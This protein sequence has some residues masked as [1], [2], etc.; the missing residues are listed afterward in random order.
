VASTFHL[1]D[2]TK[3]PSPAQAQCRIEFADGRVIS[4]CLT[5]R[6]QDR[7]VATYRVTAPGTYES[8]VIENKNFPD[9]IGARVRTEFRVDN[10]KLFTTSYPPATKGGAARSVIKVESIWVRE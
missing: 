8:Q 3:S 5:S 9:V 4:E 7:I 1:D 10:G 2:G 6:G